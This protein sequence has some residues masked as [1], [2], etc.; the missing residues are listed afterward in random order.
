MIIM[1]Y[2]ADDLKETRRRFRGIVKQ[3]HGK[4]V[5][6]CCNHLTLI[7]S[8][9]L[10]WLLVSPF[11]YL[12]NFRLMPW[13]VPE[14]KNFGKTAALK[15]MC[16][17]GKCVYVE[18]G[19]SMGGRRQTFMQLRTLLKNR[20]IICV[21]PEGGRSRTGRVNTEKHTSGA[22]HLMRHVPET[23][24][25][26]VYLRSQSQKTWGKMPAKG[27]R[28]RCLVEELPLP[29]ELLAD[30]DGEANRPADAYSKSEKIDLISA[31]VMGKLA[32]M[33][34]QYFSL[35]SHLTVMI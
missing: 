3:H 11:H 13:N 33:E 24:L 20:E 30:H 35:Q 29:P 34:D 14:I 6:I 9:I 22:A 31:A 1:K 28:F 23:V 17:L 8:M 4:P 18:R 25:V 7:D 12:I 2:R 21:F 32:T 27:S 10:N 16:Y 5:L 26:C 19:G 15:V